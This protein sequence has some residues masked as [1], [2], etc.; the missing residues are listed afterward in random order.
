MLKDKGV[1]WRAFLHMQGSFSGK[2]DKPE[3]DFIN[4]IPPAIAIDQK[5]NTHN[6][7]STVG[8]STEIYDYLKLLYARA[9]RTLSPISGK[10]VKSTA[11]SDVVN[12]IMSL[13]DQSGTVLILAP[14]GTNWHKWT[15]EL[16]EKYP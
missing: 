1:T 13:L 15:D 3:V 11:V 12:Y 10:E 7:R 16:I 4:G 8:T 9:G 6:P 14:T 5:V 2:I